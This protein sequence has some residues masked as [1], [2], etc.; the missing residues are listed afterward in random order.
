MMTNPYL[1]GY[2]LPESNRLQDQA[3]TLVISVWLR[4]L[5]EA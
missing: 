1:H 4:F 3:S 5:S 2:N